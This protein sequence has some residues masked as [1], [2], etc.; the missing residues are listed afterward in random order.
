MAGRDRDLLRA[1]LPMPDRVSAR[2]HLLAGALQAEPEPAVFADLQSRIVAYFEGKEVDFS[3]VPVYLEGQGE[4]ACKVLEACR[5]VG[6]GQTVTY[7]DLARTIGRPTAAR[8]VGGALGRNP[9]P[10]IIPCHRVIGMHGGL[11]GF[12]AP[13]GIAYKDRLLRHERSTRHSSHN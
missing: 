8:A 6:L 7:G 13:G 4:F 3:D 12:S 9:I 5:K 10:L 11:C 2:A 1:S